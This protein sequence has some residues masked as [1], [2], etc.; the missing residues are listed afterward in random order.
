[1]RSRFALVAALLVL[2]VPFVPSAAA[3]HTVPGAL[4]LHLRGAVDLGPAPTYVRQQV[5]LTLPLRDRRALSSLLHD[6]QT[7]G[8]A[9]YRRWL[10]PAQFASRFAP[11]T[12]LVAQTRR[13]AT[14]A[15]LTVTE[16]SSNRTLVT[17]VGSRAQLNKAFGVQLRAVRLGST[18]FV[19][20]DRAA[21]VPLPVLAVLGLSTYNPNH[22]AAYQTY[23]LASYS[24]ADFATIYHAPA[25]VTG[26][27]QSVAIITD[28]DLRQVQRDLSTFESRFRLRRVPLTVVQTNGASTATDGATE[29][30]LDSQAS[31]GFA[32]GIKRLIAYNGNGLADIHPLNRFVTDRIAKSASASYGGCES[33]NALVGFVDAADQ[34]FQQAMAQG[35]SLW[36]STGDEGSSCS[37]L[38]NTGTPLGVPSVE[39]PSSSPYVVAVGGTSLSG[40][41]TQ[42]TREVAWVG[43]G[44]GY[45]N[46]ES[47]PSWQA[48]HGSF[49]RALGRGLPDVSLDA[50]PN[51]GYT[52]IVGGQA[53]TVGGTS[54]SAPAWNG[55][56]A[57]V[58]QKHP[59]FGFAA[60][61]LYRAPAG[62]LVDITVGSNGLWAA[63]S[64]Y[65][66]ST[67]LGSADITGLVTKLR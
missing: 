58:L 30:A 6:Q 29:Y 9:E 35:Q 1:M 17:V 51:S 55:I 22:R 23:G 32:P 60:P 20:P 16:V 14:A 42:P 13:W 67:G 62:A 28:G 54:A 2:A 46:V 26:V 36:V 15:G 21:S 38:V 63:A 48:S 3:A 37:I 65:D 41:T 11:T 7:A 10:T 33:L 43:G 4:P 50:D 52:V 39:Y 59:R 53:T 57:R 49:V 27:G 61:L 5:V 64:G 19:T 31:L 18:R 45:S 8:T 47:A 66:L 56:W 12:S 40:S 34:V 25:S 24:P 44:G